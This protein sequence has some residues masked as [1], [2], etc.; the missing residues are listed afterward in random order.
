[1][2]VFLDDYSVKVCELS[3]DV[4]FSET[5][6]NCNQKNILLKQWSRLLS[7]SEKIRRLGFC[8]D[9]IR[10]LLFHHLQLVFERSD[11]FAAAR[12]SR[13]SLRLWR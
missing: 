2:F 5:L 3:I 9:D 8:R 1:L 10:A 4:D 6:T 13:G 12:K 11:R 7:V